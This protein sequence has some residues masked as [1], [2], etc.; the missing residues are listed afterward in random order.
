MELKSKIQPKDWEIKKFEDFL[1]YIQPTPF[2]VESTNY[3][4]NYEIPVLTAGKSFILGYT[5]ETNGI[6]KNLPVIIFD[7]FTTANKLVNF[8]FKVKS[9]AMKILKPKSDNVNIKF[10]F[11]YM[12]TVRITYDT[13]K[14]YWI[15]IFSKLPIPC[16]PIQD[17][18]AIVEKIEELLSEVEHAKEQLQK[19]QQ[20]LKVYNQSLLNIL[21][22]EK[23]CKTIETVIDKLDQGWSPK[24]LNES[25]VDDNV[26]TVIKTS[27]V[28][29]GQFVS[30]ENKVLPKNLKPRE[31][32]ELKVGDILITRAG[33][34]VRVGVCCMVRETKSR[35]L[36][37][38]KVYRI[39]VNLKVIL[40]EYFELIINSPFYQRVIEKMKTGISDSGLNLTQAKF[41]K[42][43]IPV[44]SLKEQQ[45][46]ILEFES[47]LSVCNNIEETINQSLQ[48]TETL[49]QSILKKAFEGNL[50]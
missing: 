39:K 11:Y 9:S 21:V 38:D 27:A 37:C 32:H 33:P 48:Q 24:C 42:I 34:R 23:N 28:Q 16:P 1:D 18:D 41:L 35:L 7:D 2:I 40:P 15:S 6:F 22:S 4:D 20:Q 49:K 8:P 43:E 10:A 50:I 26:W 47:K 30:H 17:Q 45:S 5:N 12:Q 36:N 25:S 13:H 31:Q 44:P 29:H 3:S 19:A 46:I 14:R